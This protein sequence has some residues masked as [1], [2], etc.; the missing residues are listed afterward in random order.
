MA[1]TAL[2]GT[3]IKTVGELPEVGS[4]APGFTVTGPDLGD[5]SSADL[6]GRLVLNIFPSVDTGVCA[7]SV[8]RFNEL[9]AGLDD[10]TVL[11]VSHDLPFAQKRFCGA[12]GLENVQVGSTFR[13]DFGD[14][15]GVTQ[16]DGPM[17]GLLARAV[18]VIDADGTV[19]HT[20]LV[21]D[22]SQEPDYDAA[23]AALS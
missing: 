11:C 1:T 10:T 2:K 6:P 8:R 19:S 18:V 22:I 16:V 23:V 21:P 13:S 7:A 3:P 14:R 15:L 4:P 9:A 5:I 12:E 20:E 17:K